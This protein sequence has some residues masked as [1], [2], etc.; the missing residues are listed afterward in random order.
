MNRYLLTLVIKPEISDGDRKTLLDDVKK[1]ML[2]DTGKITKE[3][4]WGLRDLTYTIK[5]QTKGFYA[6]FEFETDP[7]VAKIL[8]KNIR[9]EEDI[10]RHLLVR[11]DIKAAKVAHVKAQGKEIESK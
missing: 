6:H 3:D 4:L 7:S 10:I 9:V 11:N 1:K 5:R 8:D 2:G